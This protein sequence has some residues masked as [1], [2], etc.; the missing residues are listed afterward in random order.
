[1]AASILNSTGNRNASPGLVE[2]WNWSSVGWPNT[3]LNAIEILCV[4]TKVAAGTPNVPTI[5]LGPLVW[6]ELVT[7]VGTGGYATWRLTIFS[8]R[9]FSEETGPV[10]LDF[11]GQQQSQTIKLLVEVGGLLSAGLIATILEST[12][13]DQSSAAPIASYINIL[14][15]VVIATLS[16][17]INYSQIQAIGA[18][19]TT[20]SFMFTLTL[21]GQSE[22][23]KVYLD[24]TTALPRAGKDIL[25]HKASDIKHTINVRPIVGV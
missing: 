2:S 22:F 25:A 15:I 8:A 1:M 19:S 17:G 12:S 9:G 16:S 11:A 10:V 21:T 14:S 7:Y 24:L 23:I 5:N 13:S 18:Y 3:T 6:E 4:A 20:I